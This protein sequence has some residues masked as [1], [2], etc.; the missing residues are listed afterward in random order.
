MVSPPPRK[1]DWRLSILQEI[2]STDRRAL[3]IKQDE[4]TRVVKT[5]DDDHEPKIAAGC[6]NNEAQ[7][8]T[9]CLS[10]SHTKRVLISVRRSKKRRLHD[11]CGNPR[12][13]TP[14]EKHCQS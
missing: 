2:N 8:Q 1:T 7:Q 4:S 12:P 9:E 14:T 13:A 3:K 10:N 5:V 6:E 11:A